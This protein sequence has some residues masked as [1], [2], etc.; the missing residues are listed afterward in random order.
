MLIAPPSAW[1]RCRPLGWFSV[2]LLEWLISRRPT[3]VETRTC[4]LTT[5]SRPATALSSASS[6]SAHPP[7]IINIG[8]AESR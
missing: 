7:K 8:H 5:R 1:R 4:L 3:R 6:L 2:L